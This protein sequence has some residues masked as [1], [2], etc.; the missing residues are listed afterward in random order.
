ME[1]VNEQVSTAEVLRAVVVEI[2]RGGAWLAAVHLQPACAG[3]A[4]PRSSSGK[5]PCV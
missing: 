4:V 5:Y 3:V 1:R 2:G